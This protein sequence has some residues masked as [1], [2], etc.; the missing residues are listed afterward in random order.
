[1]SNAIDHTIARARLDHAFLKIYHDIDSAMERFEISDGTIR[2]V[3]RM[4][5]FECR[6][7]QAYNAIKESM[8]SELDII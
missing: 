6:M 4:I 5:L 1:M 2:E 8:T 7:H 3:Y